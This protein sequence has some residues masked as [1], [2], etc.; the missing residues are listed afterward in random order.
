[1]SVADMKITTEIFTVDLF[2]YV[3]F[4][5]IFYFSSVIFLPSQNFS[6]PFDLM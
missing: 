2:K 6:I 5:E 3:G 4:M 1:M